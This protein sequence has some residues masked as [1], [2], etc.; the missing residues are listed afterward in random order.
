MSYEEPIIQ[1][2]GLKDLKT[3]DQERVKELAANY[4]AKLQRMVQNI[5]SLVVHIKE[6]E[7]TG[8]KKEDSKTKRIKYVVHVRM[9]APMKTFASSKAVDWDIARVVHKAFR[10]VEAEVKHAFRTDSS[11]QK[12]YFKG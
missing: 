3:E 4:H 9:I 6:H 5:T 12:P 7:K 11:Y 1:F 10:D 2:V 8:K